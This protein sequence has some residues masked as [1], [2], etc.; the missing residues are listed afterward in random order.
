MFANQI[1]K[2]TQPLENIVIEEKLRDDSLK[3]INIVIAMKDLPSTTPIAKRIGE[4]LKES[5]GALYVDSPAIIG[6]TRF[7]AF[8]F[9]VPFETYLE[10][11]TKA[12]PGE[13]FSV[14]YEW[15][16]SNFMCVASNYSE[17]KEG[18]SPAFYILLT[19]GVAERLCEIGKYKGK[20]PMAADLSISNQGVMGYKII[21]FKNVDENNQQTVKDVVEVV[22][23]YNANSGILTLNQVAVLNEAL[24]EVEYH[25]NRILSEPR[26]RHPGTVIPLFPDRT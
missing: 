10:R 7:D 14:G 2:L 13:A 24:M 12:K 20:H 23:G 22:S 5:H 9:Q 15:L 26:V 17:I 18:N 25:T 8:K 19:D 4:I 16:L 6:A 3:E 21:G 11:V 1:G